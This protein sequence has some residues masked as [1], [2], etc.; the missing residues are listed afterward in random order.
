M[1]KNFK[2]LEELLINYQK[3]KIE[4]V[5]FNI[6]NKKND[7]LERELIISRIDNALSILTPNEMKIIQLRYLDGLGK[8]SWYSISDKIFLSVSRCHEIKKDAL[9]KLSDLLE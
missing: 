4:F 1:S 3:F 2:S 5:N 6:L 9:K 8:E 7:A